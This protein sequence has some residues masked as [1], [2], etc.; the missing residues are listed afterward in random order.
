MLSLTKSQLLKLL[1]YCVYIIYDGS[2]KYSML[3]SD[4]LR[5]TTKT[6][7]D[8]NNTEIIIIMINAYL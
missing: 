3:K 2:Y 8:M 6:K 4:I 7:T 5:D 1:T